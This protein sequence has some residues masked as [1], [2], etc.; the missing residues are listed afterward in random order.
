MKHDLDE[1]SQ[2]SESELNEID[3]DFDFKN[4][5]EIDFHGLKTLIKQTFQD[6]VQYILDSELADHIISL[7]VGSVV[8]V[9]GGDDPYA[10][11]T[12]LD[13]KD[14]FFD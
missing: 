12:V 8:K 9:D 1:S 2:N 13:R 6:D 5:S 10:F 3:V 11:I 4:A 14:V 7:D